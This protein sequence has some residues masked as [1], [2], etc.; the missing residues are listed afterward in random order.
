MRFLAVL[1]AVYLFASPLRVAFTIYEP[2]SSETKKGAVGISVDYWKIVANDLNLSYRFITEPSCNALIKSL[3]EKKADVA[4]NESGFVHTKKVLF[5][6]PYAA[7]P[8][9]LATQ[10]DV[11]FIMGADF[12]KN[13]LIAVGKGDIE[14]A[15]EKKYPYLHLVRVSNINEALKLV[16]EG[17]V[18]GA[19]DVLPVIAYK[20]NKYQYNDLKISGELDIM[21][22]FRFMIRKEYA[23]LIPRINGAIDNITRCERRKIYQKW[24]KAEKK[25]KLKMI[26]F[27]MLILIIITLIVWNL[28]LKIKLKGEYEQN[29][30]LEK[31]ANYDKL[32][33]AYNRQKLEE[34]LKESVKNYKLKSEPF[35]VVFFDVDNFKQINDTYGHNAGDIV[36]VEVSSIVQNSIRRKD[37]FGRWGG[38]EFMIVL[39]NC[40]LYQGCKIANNLRKKIEEHHFGVDTKITCSFGVGEYKGGDL[41]EFLEEVDRH[42][43]QA[44]KEG[45]NRVIC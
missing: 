14:Y 10:G 30:M 17:K 12:L 24:V 18:F 25:P 19:V 34:F 26:L 29:I 20:L 33:G 23:Y 43:Y 45:K 27:S 32:T 37:V 2:F 7:F 13:R 4:L 1:F 11:G 31:L 38:E 40:E 28:K 16:R 21:F 42:L 15:I 41:K 6:K 39:E 35:C 9:V 44:K 8:L 3:D 5:S 36:L 22:P